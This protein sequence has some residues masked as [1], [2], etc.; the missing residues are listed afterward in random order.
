MIVSKWCKRYTFCGT[1]SVA[2]LHPPRN[3]A[4]TA[5]CMLMKRLGDT[6]FIGCCQSESS[7]RYFDDAPLNC[8]RS[9]REFVVAQF[10]IANLSA[11]L[12]VKSRESTYEYK[13][14][15]RNTRRISNGSG[16]GREE[17]QKARLPT[18]WVGGGPRRS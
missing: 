10:K 17:G 15:Y 4:E 3:H 6:R 16:G 8:Y 13:L 2:A 11:G 5:A 12:R 9:P 14:D 7:K 1:N 18:G